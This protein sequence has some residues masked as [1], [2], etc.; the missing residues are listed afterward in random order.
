[1]LRC[2]GC[3][4]ACLL[5]LAVVAVDLAV[6]DDASGAV[7]FKL[8]SA[9]VEGRPMFWNK[10]SAAVLA[11][12]GRLWQFETG[13]AKDVE[14]L[15]QP[16]RSQSLVKMQG[17]LQ[18]EFGSAFEV[19]AAGRYLVVHPRGH[20]GEWSQRFD[21]LY[22]S[23]KMFFAVRGFQLQEPEFPLVAII[24]RSKDEFYRYARK[25]KT[26][27][28]SSILGYYSS[29]TNRVAM[30]DVT[31]GRSNTAW[32][33]NAETIIHEATHQ[34]A[35]NTGIHSRFAPPPQWVAEGLGTLFEARGIWD[36]H[37]TQPSERVNRSRLAQFRSLLT[38][39]KP[40]TLVQLVS[41]DK[42]FKSDIDLAYAEAWALTYYLS[43]TQPTK[44]ADYLARTARRPEFQKYSS[45]QRLADFTAVFGDNFALLDAQFRQYLRDVQ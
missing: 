9:T 24:M 25:E 13:Q 18:R 21:E 34:T 17:D 19:S 35:F 2:F 43:Q 44:Y 23:F 6:G 7:R 36:A 41:S 42:L 11:D 31:A 20:G 37:S 45:A 5:Y 8:G 4:L 33:T 29:Q 15:N 32:Q 38:K 10:S 3:L 14:R 22:R 27:L 1:M 39:H 12:D 16:F 28:Q 26:Q 40:D 30:Y